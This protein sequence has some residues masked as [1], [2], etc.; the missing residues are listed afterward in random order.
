M[1]TSITPATSVDSAL[2]GPVVVVPSSQSV[3]D[4]WERL[5]RIPLDR[6]LLTPPPGTA[7]EDDAADSRHT[8]GVS[9]ELVD[10]V[11]VAKAMGWYESRIA[12][13]LAYFLESY[14]EVHKI[15]LVAG[16]DG[17]I[18]LFPKLV[19]K[20]DVSFVSFTR[21]P[22]AKIPRNK[23][24]PVAPN[25][26]VEVLSEGNTAGEMQRKLEEYFAAGVTIVWYIEPELQSAKAYTAV[27]QVE[28]IGPGGVLRGGDVLPGFEL[29]LAKLF[30]KVGPR[31]DA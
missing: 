23:S 20:P 2:D 30:D 6:I 19:R 9:C 12:V 13:T 14:L 18:R 11:L 24:L 4:L 26:A 27:D 16:G 15:G 8:L 29:P 10:G 22:S 5:G 3:A 1:S 25:L 17:P 7:T 31:E 28:E 21:L